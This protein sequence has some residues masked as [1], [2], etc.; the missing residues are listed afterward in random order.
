[1]PLGVCS[2]CMLLYRVG[3]EWISGGNG[4]FVQLGLDVVG[5]SETM[6]VGLRWYL[7][8]VGAR[9]ELGGSRGGGGYAE[10]SPACRW[11]IKHSMCRLEILPLIPLH[12]ANLIDMYIGEYFGSAS[13]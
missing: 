5:V 7:L 6:S 3:G 13:V 2:L 11:C 1:M 10:T 12:R 4:R 8:V 9:S